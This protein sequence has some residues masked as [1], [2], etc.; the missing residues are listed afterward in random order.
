MEQRLS[1]RETTQS[2]TRHEQDFGLRAVISGREV[3]LFLH[4]LHADTREL[5]PEAREQAI[6]HFLTALSQTEEKTR[7]SWEEARPRLRPVLRPLTFGQ[8]LELARPGHAMVGHEVLPFLR[9]LI[10]IDYE[11]RA[12]YLQQEEL[13]SWGVSFEEVLAAA[14]ANLARFVPLSTE[15]YE[16]HPGPIWS[17]ESDQFHESS[18]LLRPGFL[19]SF[20][21]KVEGRPIAIVPDRGTLWIAGDAHSETVARL[22]ESAEREYQAS[23]RATSPALYTVDEAMRV[24]P[25]ARPQEDELAYRVRRG[26]RL[27]AA[28]EY[29]AQKRQLDQSKG[30]EEEGGYF[31]ANVMLASP[32]GSPETFTYCVWSDEQGPGDLLPEVDLI[33]LPETKEHVLL[34]PWEEVRRIVGDRLVA[35]PTLSPRRY[36]PTAWPTPE[37]FEHLRA[38]ALE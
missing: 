8:G 14:H 24:V 34:V 3:S 23:A 19:S 9:E 18:W 10:S 7:L 13:E 17:I 4:R 20:E 15:L 28:C 29:S 30:G 5:S 31:V 33:A 11:D 21:K 22:C 38:A 12:A 26:H 1:A 2:V 27:L 32:K 36:R 16:R 6:E 25:Y 35:E 37:M